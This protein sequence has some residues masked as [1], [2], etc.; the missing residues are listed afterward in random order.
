MAHLARCPSVTVLESSHDEVYDPFDHVVR[1][2]AV[3][4]VPPAEGD[5]RRE[6][7]NHLGGEVDVPNADYPLGRR[8]SDDAG[9]VLEKFVMGRGQSFA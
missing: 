7:G 6:E 5:Q 4:H 1:C 3:T 2:Q 9:H 8:V